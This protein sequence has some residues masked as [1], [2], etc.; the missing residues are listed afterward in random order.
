M[1]L[2]L[3]KKIENEKMYYLV[4]DTA[5][6]D[7]YYEFYQ[8][9]NYKEIPN[10]ENI[11]YKIMGTELMNAYE[12]RDFSPVGYKSILLV[13][14]GIIIEGNVINIGTANLLYDLVQN[15]RFKDLYNVINSFRKKLSIEVLDYY[16]NKIL[17]I[18]VS[19]LSEDTQRM[20]KMLLQKLNYQKDEKEF[21]KEIMYLSIINEYHKAY[22][23]VYDAEK[24][25]KSYPEW[26]EE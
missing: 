10:V 4:S 17:E 18:E 16:K 19:Q 21:F 11:C 7:T 6:N 12:T 14:H 3:R 23:E 5:K 1:G 22:T 2:K 20:Y 9:D 25:I 15:I 8:F 26:N 24:R 13:K